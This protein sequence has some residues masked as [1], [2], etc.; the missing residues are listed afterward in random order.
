MAHYGDGSVWL[1]P[2]MVIERVRKRRAA[3]HDNR[4]DRRDDVRSELGYRVVSEILARGRRAGSDPANGRRIGAARYE[5]IAEEVI[6]E[7]GARQGVER[8]G[9]HCGWGP[10]T[11]THTDGCEAGWVEVGDGSAVTACPYCS[12]TRAHILG[13]THSTMDAGRTLRDTARTTR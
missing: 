7:L 12:P 3:T 10:C 11:C 1:M 9:Q 4:T 2:N 8:M 6:V 13:S 5:Q